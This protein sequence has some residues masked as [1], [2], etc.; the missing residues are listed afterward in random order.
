VIRNNSMAR[1]LGKRGHQ[2]PSHLVASIKGIGSGFVETQDEST[3]KLAL[4]IDPRVRTIKAQPFTVRL[5]LQKIFKTRSEAVKA[6][7]TTTMEAGGEEE[8]LER[9]YTPDFLVELVTPNPLVVES[10]SAEATAR[11]SDVLERRGRILNA[12][13][14]QYLVVPSTAIK[15]RGLHANLVHLRDATKFKQ[16][17]D[18]TE[19]LAKLTKLV[20]GKRGKFS[21]GELRG[22]V[23]DTTIYLGVISGILGCDL[24]SGHFSVETVMWQAYGDLSHLQLLE[25]EQ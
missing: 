4:D 23:S 11:I 14:Y 20:D 12:L 25:W 16:D 17:N 1:P 19:Q 9:V 15:V 22:K 24:R 7:A 21:A 8:D 13:G 2:R 5:D 6:N 10:K 3:T 18:A